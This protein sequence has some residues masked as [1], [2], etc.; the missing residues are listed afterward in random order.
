[1]G[2]VND[3]LFGKK[4]K[5]KSVSKLTKEQEPLQES[6]INAALA[7][8]AGGSFG[9]SADYWRSLLSNEP[10]AFDAFAAPDI[11]KFQQEI[12]PD[13]SEQFASMGSGALSS[14]G[15][16]NAAVNAYTDL[17][18]RLAKLRAELRGQAAQNLNQIGQQGLVPTKENYYQQGSEGALSQLAPAIGTLGGSFA[19]P[20]GAAAGGAAGNWLKNAWGGDKVGRNTNPYGGASSALTGGSMIGR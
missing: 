11:R 16:R 12:I 5:M 1:M 15:F 8:G 14:S 3:F 7:P 17:G 10:G 18:E 13:I 6:L 2:G 9:E 20:L 4:G 19:G